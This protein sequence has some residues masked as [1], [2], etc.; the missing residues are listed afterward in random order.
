M[1]RTRNTLVAL[2]AMS[3][4]GV[5]ACGEDVVDDDVENNVDSVVD[6]V[7]EDVEDVDVDVDVNDTGG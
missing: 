4:M 7:Q 5:A 3:L 6:D 2:A 1:N